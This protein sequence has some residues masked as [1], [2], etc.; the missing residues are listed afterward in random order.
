VAVALGLTVF[1]CAESPEVVAPLARQP[2]PSNQ[3]LASPV[4]VRVVTR[5]VPLATPQ[6]ATQTIGILGGTISLPGAGLTVVVPAFAVSTS[7]TITVTALAGSKVAYEFEPH[8]TQFN[9]P[10]IATQSLAGTS[11][12]NGSLV[13]PSLSAGYFADSLTTAGNT[14]LVSELLGVTLDGLLGRASF[15]ISH[16]SGYLLAT[17]R[18]E[19][20]DEE[21]I[22]Q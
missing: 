10:L 2:A 16:F 8:G 15:S 12:W 5:D 21:V 20:G 11:V 3:L 13:S 19:P 18:T 4:R 9:V 6:T 17:G 1:S 22:Q 14:A 7:T